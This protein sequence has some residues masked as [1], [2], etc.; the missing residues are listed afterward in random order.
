MDTRGGSD[1]AGLTGM[2]DRIGAVGGDLKIMSSPGRGMSVQ[3]MI[4]DVGSEAALAA[5]EAER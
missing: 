2:R 4:P 3:G 1:G 5:S